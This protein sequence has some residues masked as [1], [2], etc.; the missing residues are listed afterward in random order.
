MVVKG[1]SRFVL[2]FFSSCSH[3]LLT[4][5]LNGQLEQ[6]LD[7]LILDKVILKSPLRSPRL[8]GRVMLFLEAKG[9]RL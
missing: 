6:I 4:T 1:I 8:C 7:G 2:T 9:R 3:F 5:E